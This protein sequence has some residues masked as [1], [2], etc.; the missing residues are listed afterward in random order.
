MLP[1]SSNSRILM[2]PPVENLA[3]DYDI[4]EPSSLTLALII[5]GVSTG[6]TS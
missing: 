3:K 1:P 5:Y 6:T 4:D 2:A